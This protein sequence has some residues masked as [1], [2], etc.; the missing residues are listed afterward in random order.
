VCYN[1]YM[2]DIYHTLEIEPI[3][4]EIASYSHTEIS[5]Q[6]IL[7]LKML[8]SPEEISS[9]LVILNEMMHLLD[10]KEHLPIEASFDLTKYLDIVAKSGVLSV[11]E[12]DHVALDIETS[13]K[14]SLYFSRVER[15]LYPNLIKITDQFYDLSKLEDKIRSVIS[16]NLQ[17]RDD[18]SP[19]LRKI[20]GQITKLT[21]EVRDSSRGLIAKYS[22]YLSENTMALR[23]DHFVLPVKT[24]NKNK[25]PGIIHDISDTGMTTFIEPESLVQ[26]SNKICSLRVDEKE[27]IYRLLRYLSNEVALNKNEVEKNNALISLLDEYSSKAT[28]SNKHRSLCANLVDE[29]VIEL[30]GARHPL[31]NPE[32]VVEN[33]FVLNKENRIILISGPNAGGK[34]VALK[35]LGLLVM[36]NQMGLAIPTKIPANLGYFPRIYADIGDNQSL[37][38][39]LS[40]FAAHVS[41]LSTITYFVKSK[42]LVLL[43]E[44]G[45]GTSPKEGEAMAMAV[46]EFL[47][48]KGTLCM[49]SSHFDKMKEFAYATDHIENAMMVFDEKKLVPTYHFKIGASG[50]SYGLEMASRYHLHDEVVKKAKQYLNNDQTTDINDVLDELNHLVNENEELNKSLKERERLLTG[51]ENNLKHQEEIFSSKKET[52]LEDVKIERQKILDEANAK[53]DFIMKNLD[54]SNLKL[55][56]VI[57]AK[58]SLKELTEEHEDEKLSL[59]TEPIAVGDYVEIQHLGLTGKVVKITSKKVELISQDGFQ[60]QAKLDQLVKVD[61]PANNKR[62]HTNIDHELQIKSNVGLELNIIGYHIDEGI[63]AL[64]KYLDECRLRGFKTV[65]IIHGMGTGQLRTA[66]WN[67]LKKQSYIEEYHYGGYFDGGTG[68]TVVTFK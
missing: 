65:R 25:V 42:D 63:Q 1:A 8:T 36:M 21:N 13:K 64:S 20:R 34:T 3:L 60:V 33:D 11:L 54:S 46:T 31:I 52:L 16:E 37:S 30:T 43:D 12:L 2:L 22:E 39:N 18:A 55:H 58:T 62:L 35:T 41:N 27:E 15:H 10:V 26:L 32:V 24:A 51:R 53:V 17:I 5:K 45:T 9:T 40:T 7:N 14:L 49:I 4:N 59:S 67:Y 48:Q 28:Y 50:R 19:E 29:Q 66:V 47:L 38:D 57:Q 68:A 23:N 6:K 56:E 61:A 44:L